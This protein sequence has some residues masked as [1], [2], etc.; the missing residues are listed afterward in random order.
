MINDLSAIDFA[1]VLFGAISGVCFRQWRESARWT[2]A[3]EILNDSG[4]I[5]VVEIFLWQKS[6]AF[7]RFPRTLRIDGGW[8]EFS[9]NGTNSRVSRL[10]AVANLGQ[11][12]ANEVF[13]SER[14]RHLNS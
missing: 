4:D 5:V 8:V 13:E 14:I 2:M 6:G 12:Y 10:D 9:D 11:W 7:K 3:H 1:K